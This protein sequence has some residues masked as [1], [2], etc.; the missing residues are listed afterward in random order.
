MESTKRDAAALTLSIEDLR[1]TASLA[2]L[3]TGDDELEAAFPAFREMLSYFAA[4][5]TADTEEKTFDKTSAETENMPLTHFRT[6]DEPSAK[7]ELNLSETMLDKS[8]ERDGR[9]IVVPNIL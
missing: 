5:Q 6:D 7:V 9:F 2:H 1:I 8:G 4:M 3:N